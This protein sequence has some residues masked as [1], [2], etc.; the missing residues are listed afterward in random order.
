MYLELVKNY[1]QWIFKLYIIVKKIIAE[2]FFIHSRR[3]AWC[4]TTK[5]FQK[6]SILTIQDFRVARDFFGGS[7]YGKQAII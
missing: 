4:D 2:C 6:F 5:K 7:G 1:F 3:S